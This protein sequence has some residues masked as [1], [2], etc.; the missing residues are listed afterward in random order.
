VTSNVFSWKE[1]IE[2]GYEPRLY[3]FSAEKVPLGEYDASLDFKIWAKNIMAI[4]CYF[5]RIKSAEKFQLTVYCKSTGSYKIEN[6]NV[7][8]AQCAISCLY[9]IKVDADEKKRIVFKEAIAL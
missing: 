5:T 3:P 9:R 2:K 6:G 4:G 8:F 1:A 7:D